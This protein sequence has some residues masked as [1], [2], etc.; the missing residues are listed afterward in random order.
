MEETHLDSSWRFLEWGIDYTLWGVI[1]ISP[2]EF[3]SLISYSQSSEKVVTRRLKAINLVWKLSDYKNVLLLR[4][5]HFL[6]QPAY[7]WL[8]NVEAEGPSSHPPPHPQCKSAKDIL[9]LEHSVGV[10]WSFRWW[11]LSF[12]LC[13]L[14]S[15][16]P[17]HRSWSQE[18]SLINTLQTLSESAS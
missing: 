18:Y 6:G 13:P 14:L 1:Q 12:S 15:S 17:L 7:Q 9:A 10:Q 16:L 11:Q 5:S 2:S 8:V 3:L 4:L